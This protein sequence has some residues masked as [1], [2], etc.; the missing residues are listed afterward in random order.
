MSLGDQL[1]A[2]LDRAKRLY[3]PAPS[4]PSKPSLTPLQTNGSTHLVLPDSPARNASSPSEVLSSPSFSIAD[5]DEESGDEDGSDEGPESPSRKARPTT[6][7]RTLVLSLEAE[8]VHD[9]DGESLRSPIDSHSRSLTLE[10][11]EVFRKGTA[12]GAADVSDE[13]L[14]DVSGEDLKK[15]VSPC[16]CLRRRTSANGCS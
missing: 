14:G 7:N 15:E 1:S 3:D 13:E 11:G 16:S 5:S 9:G 2:I 10:E 6:T 4:T 12:L 8:G